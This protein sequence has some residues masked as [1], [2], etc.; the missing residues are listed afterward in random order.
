MKNFVITIIAIFMLSSA[1]AGWNQEI[2]KNPMGRDDIWIATSSSTNTRNLGFPYGN[3]RGHLVVRKQGDSF[4]VLLYVDR[5]QFL[6]QMNGCGITVRIDDNP[7]EEMSAVVPADHSS[8][9]IFVSNGEKFSKNIIGSKKILI[10]ATFYQKGS[11]IFYFN[12]IGFE[13]TKVGKSISSIDEERRKNE[14]IQ[15]E[16]EAIE[17]KTYDERDCQELRAS[18]NRYPNSIY[19]Q[20]IFDYFNDKQRCN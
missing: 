3:I 16:M 13:K 7:A 11:N 8:D 20:R 9:V 1:V 4:N 10:E 19:A 17:L 6:C 15:L 5:G 12:T 2:R 18:A 14:K